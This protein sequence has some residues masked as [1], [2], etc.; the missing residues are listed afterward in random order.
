[1][2]RPTQREFDELLIEIDLLKIDR[3]HLEEENKL[4]RA[5]YLANS[6]QEKEDSTHAK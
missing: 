6:F 3:R 2:H 4:L 5:F 1:M